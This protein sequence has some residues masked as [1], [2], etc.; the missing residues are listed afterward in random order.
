MKTDAHAM[1]TSAW[2]MGTDAVSMGTAKEQPS[3]RSR[4][5][6]NGRVS[7]PLTFELMERVWTKHEGVISIPLSEMF[8]AGRTNFNKKLDQIRAA[9]E[10]SKYLINKHISKGAVQT[11]VYN[12]ILKPAWDKKLREVPAPFMD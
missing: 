2:A 7:H 6:P 8:R 4:K 9:S 5:K 3:G 11:S 1:G 12:D 10:E